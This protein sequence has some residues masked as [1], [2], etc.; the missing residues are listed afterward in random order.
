[1]AGEIQRIGV[2]TSGGDAPGMNAAVRAVVRKGIFHGLTIFGIHRGYEGLIHG[3]LQEMSIGSVADIVLRG[4][5]VLKTARS[6]EMK[7]PAGQK[8]AFEQLQK[9]QI[10]ALVVIGGDGS[11]RGAQTLA[12]QGVRII[13]IPGTIDNDIAGTDLTIGF[14]TA[15]NTVVDAVSKI[16]DT[17]SSHDRT[18]IVEVMGRNCGNI[19]LQAGLACGAESILVPE[20]PYDLDE[21]S[22]KLKRGHQRGKNHSIILVSEGVGSAFKVG[23]ELRARS[24]FETRITVLGHL[25]R[26]GNPSALDAVIAAAMG[27]KAVQSL[28]DQETNRMTAYINQT[29]ISRPLDD[30]YGTRRPLN[31]ELYDLANEL[32]I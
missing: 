17:A 11:F 9:R 4:G 30:A 5:T 7:T 31:R 8:K 20:I 10:D 2:L 6:E 1:M 24:G 3:E 27:G 25:Q 12:A 14:D 18:F 15:V 26:G 22:N 19:A 32:S 28:L 29:V 21:I 16:R 23:E 13:G